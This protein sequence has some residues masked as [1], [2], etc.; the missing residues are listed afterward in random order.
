MAGGGRLVPYMAGLSLLIALSSLLTL[1][2]PAAGSL[3][4]HRGIYGAR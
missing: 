3:L 4:R 2:L 1:V